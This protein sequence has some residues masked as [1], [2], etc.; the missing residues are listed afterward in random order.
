M[1][2]LA[3]LAALI[4]TVSP[5]S[6]AQEA[7]LGVAVVQFE[8]DAEVVR[9]PGAYRRAVRRSV[10]A[11]VAAGRRSSGRAELV[12]FPEYTGALAA[13][14]V[15]E[16][17]VAEIESVDDFLRRIA[18]EDPNVRSAGDY[19]L[20]HAVEA[21]NL[22]VQTFGREARRNNL[23]IVAGTAFRPVNGGLRNRA[24]VFSPAGK[25]AYFQ[26]KVYLTPFEE[27]VLGIEAGDIGLAAGFSIRDWQVG[28]TICR[29]TFFSQWESVQRQH[30]LWIDI[31]AN[32]TAFDLEEQKRFDRALPSRLRASRVPFGATACLTGSLLD[33]YWEGESSFISV[34][35]GPLRILEKSSSPRN[36]EVLFRELVP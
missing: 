11:A 10:R 1:K 32:G 9:S 17:E 16:Q 33:L 36:S 20:R 4:L 3:L 30:S 19:F 8:A 18:E 27:E 29:D 31:K 24:L 2:I 22:L 7:P 15:G 35:G 23:W 13:L 26:D 21:Q 28:L 14:A 25:L 5:R 34:A 12:V 6:L